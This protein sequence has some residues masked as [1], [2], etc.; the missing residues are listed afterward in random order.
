MRSYVRDTMADD[1]PYKIEATGTSLRLLERLVEA[2]EPVGVTRLAA[3][4][5][6]S[7][8]VAHNHLSTLRHLGYVVKRNRKYEPALRSLAQGERTRRA[9]RVYEVGREEVDNLAEATGEVVLL[10]V[11]EVE[12]GVAVC[13]SGRSEEWSPPYCAGER[14]PLHVNAPG[15]A[16]LASLPEDRTASILAENT[17]E[18]PTDRTVT[19]SEKL[20]RR[21]RKVRDDGVSFC[22]EEQFPG[23][24]GVAAPIRAAGES[25]HA[26]L[27]VVG[28]AER[29][30]GRYLEEDLAGQVIST[31][32]SIEVSLTE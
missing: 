8:S 10:F 30:N 16:I 13:I 3:D 1:P 12:R 9:M 2:A 24:I 29:L 6:L 32:K 25:R 4:L 20:G 28:P 14:M 7:K 5:G 31:A 26:A 27:G 21:L 18:A 11:E 23:I 15:K 19:D 17:L 22:R